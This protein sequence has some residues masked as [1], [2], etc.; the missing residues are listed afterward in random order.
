MDKKTI[1]KRYAGKRLAEVIFDGSTGI[2][3]ALGG[4]PCYQ[5]I[6]AWRNNNIP[7]KHR[8]KLVEAARAKG[9]D[10][11]EFNFRGDL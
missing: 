8:A 7:A 3:A 2:S 5:V 11:E 10:V 4:K 9:F 1:L 6:W